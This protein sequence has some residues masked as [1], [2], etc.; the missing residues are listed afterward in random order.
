MVYCG[1]GSTCSSCLPSG[2]CDSNRSVR[3]VRSVV[4]LE[5]LVLRQ[6]LVDFGRLVLEVQLVLDRQLIDLIPNSTKLS[7]LTR[8]DCSERVLCS[9]LLV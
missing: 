6:S 1:V 7:P 3:S 9:A 8:V 2:R 4:D 5:L